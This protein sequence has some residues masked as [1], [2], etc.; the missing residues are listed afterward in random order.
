MDIVLASKS[1][2]REKLLK[3]IV[4]EFIVFPSSVDELSIEERDPV[5]FAENAAA[6]KAKDVAGQFPHS[7]VIGADTIVVLENRI[8]GKP[9]DLEDAKRMLHALS[10]TR[11]KVITGLALYKK[12]EEKLSSGHAISYVTF[13]QLDDNEI[14]DYLKC[15]DFTDRAGGYGI[16][17]V[18]DDFSGHIEGSYDN[19]VGLP[20]EKLKEML[21]D[22]AEPVFSVNIVDIA[23]PHNW[24]V[25]KNGR[26]VVFVPGAVLGDKVKVRMSKKSRSF[27][28]AEIIQVEKESPF[29]NKAVC[30][31]F[32]KCGGC[33][34]QNL[35][36]EKQLEI[37]QNYL[38][39]TL[40]R[41]GEVNFDNV[42]TEPIVP[43]PDIFHYRN[44]MEYSFGEVDGKVVLGLR[45]RS[46]PFQ[47]YGYEVVGLDKCP[48]FSPC[49]DKILPVFIDFARENSL[50][51]F[52]PGRKKGFLRHLVL[53]EAKNTRELMAMLV[54]RSGEIPPLVKLAEK[55]FSE[56]ANIKSFYLILN[57]QI[58]DVVS[59][60]K[61]NFLCGETFINEHMGDLSFKIYPQ[62]FFQPNTRA[63]ELM[64]RK[65]S[66]FARQ[67][68]CR[69]ILGLYCG[70]GPIEIF[71]A[72][73]AQE[74]IGI[75]SN[76]VNISNARE[77]AAL[78]KIDN[79]VFYEGTVGTILEKNSFKDVDL[80]VMD[81]PRGG[82]TRK[83]VKRILE[84]NV[85]R[86]IC[87]SCNPAALARDI[88]VLSEN[89]YVL[90][91]LVPFD[92]FPHTTHMETLVLLEKNAGGVSK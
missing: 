58:S 20:V 73:F 55:L 33:S 14:E 8:F 68:N 76:P 40:T 31:H 77:N 57:D 52:N 34:F 2:R 4:N 27:A 59:F 43:S 46:T 17:K 65:I 66:E 1:K 51:A 10:G 9:K 89:G 85:P 42:Q 13:R 54:T 24:G 91:N 38:L 80:L 84:L 53:R 86:I 50:T 92:F 87:A 83:A 70:A 41:I 56:V 23:L 6:A 48:I 45:Q 60:Q 15:D 16:Q 36:Y 21:S 67:G 44:K 88:K 22:F 3:K 39:Q 90:K 35:Q 29:R 79:C 63:A 49:V 62:T 5:K 26:L 69:K 30:P 72:S 28:Y 32:G 71:L 82:I 11:H 19:V 81:P 74:V 64:Y 47:K 12:D 18:G 25:G 61:K 37:K 78:N 7:I 75:D